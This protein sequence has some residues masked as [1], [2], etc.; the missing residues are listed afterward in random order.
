MRLHVAPMGYRNTPTYRVISVE[1][2]YTLRWTGKTF[3]GVHKNKAN[4]WLIS[5]VVKGMNTKW[6]NHSLSIA[7]KDVWVLKDSIQKD[8][9]TIV[10]LKSA[11]TGWN[12][13]TFNRE[14]FMID[15]CK[16]PL[17]AVPYFI[18]GSV[19]AIC[20]IPSFQIVGNE[21]RPVI[22]RKILY[23]DILKPLMNKVFL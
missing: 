22:D 7:T 2:T 20:I 9:I 19:Y 21:V 6:L 1:N 17:Y 18:N 5:A 8:V 12:I 15:E 4:P 16:A 11:E 13:N 3:T 23:E 14:Y 10:A